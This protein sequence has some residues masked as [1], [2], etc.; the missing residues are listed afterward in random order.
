MKS[1]LFAVLLL[2]GTAAAAQDTS[3]YPPC[4]SSVMDKCTET[5]MMHKPMMKHR[6][7]TKHHKKMA[8]KPMASKGMMKP[9]PADTAPPAAPAN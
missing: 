2:T 8:H 6:K 9:A 1:M 4:S 5:G 7:M 3:A